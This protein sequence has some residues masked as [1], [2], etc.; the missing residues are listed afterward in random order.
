MLQRNEVMDV[1]VGNK[2]NAQ[3]KT[4]VY[5]SSILNISLLIDNQNQ[6]KNRIVRFC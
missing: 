3:K 6:R 5:F 2:L 1:Y 4:F